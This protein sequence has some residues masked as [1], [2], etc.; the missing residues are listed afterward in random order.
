MNKCMLFLSLVLF[1]A[2]GNHVLQE[3]VMG[4]LSMHELSMVCKFGGEPNLFVAENEDVY[5]SWI[6]YI[7][8]SRVELRFAKLN[9]NSWSKPVT[10]ASGDNWFV[11][12]ADFPSLIAYHDGGQTL[13][14]HWLQKRS[15][16]TYDYDIHITQSRD[17]GLTWAP[18]FLPHR[19]GV[20]AEHGFVSLL[21][22]SSDLIFATWL[23]GRNSKS[24]VSEED[25]DRPGFGD[26]FESHDHGSGE[27][28][29][30]GGP[31]SLRSAMFDKNGILYDEMELDD[32]V[33]DCCQTS[34][35]MTDEGLVVVYRDRSDDEVRDISIVRQVDGKWL[36]SESIYDDGWKISGCP[37]NGPVVKSRKNLVAVAWFTMANDEPMVKV[38]FSKDAGKSFREPI[39]VDIG[40]PL[41]RVDLSFISDSE[42]GISWL[43]QNDENANI[44]FVKVAKNGQVGHSFNATGSSA[45]RQSGF[46]QMVVVDDRV[47]MAWTNTDSTMH[48]KA[49]WFEID[50]LNIDN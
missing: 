26:S 29:H 50:Q 41:G 38:A 33:C 28:G 42:I 5:L 10:V 46:P 24:T 12:W 16:G 18:S 40:N 17:Q 14:A 23:D 49:A 13:A 35:A 45:S 4:D 6:E 21:P 20:S 1:G 11:N 32:R 43:E 7:G 2:C 27:H 48:V 39:R 3:N 31:M 22:V 30:G 19:D 25:S 15:E 44:V 34:A 9:G 36:P 8:G 37:V 47:I